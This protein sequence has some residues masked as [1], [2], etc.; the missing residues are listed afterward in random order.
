MSSDQLLSRVSKSI[1]KNIGSKICSLTKGKY[2]KCLSEQR[3]TEEGVIG[4][5]KPLDYNPVV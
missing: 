4:Q 5:V 3:L 1:E 2:W